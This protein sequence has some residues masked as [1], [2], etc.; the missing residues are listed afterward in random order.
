MPPKNDDTFSFQTGCMMPFSRCSFWK[1]LFYT[2]LFLAMRPL[3][4]TDEIYYVTPN[5]D[6]PCHITSGPCHTLNYYAPNF[7][8][9]SPFPPQAVMYFLPGRHNLNGYHVISF[10][11]FE[12]L[13]LTSSDVVVPSSSVVPFETPSEVICSFEGQAGFVFLFVNNLVIANLT[14]TSCGI[15]VANITAALFLLYD[16]NVTLLHTVIQN[17]T[18]FGMLG[19][20]NASASVAIA[21]SVFLYNGRG[22]DDIGGGIYLLTLP[23]IQDGKKSDLNIYIESSVFMYGDPFG[24]AMEIYY[25]CFPIHININNSKFVGKLPQKRLSLGSN[26][27]LHMIY[28]DQCRRHD[29]VITITNSHFLHGTSQAF[30]GGAFIIITENASYP[31]LCTHAGIQRH[32][33][34]LLLNN[35][36]Q[37]ND[38]INGVGGGLM[39]F[40]V[41]VCQSYHTIGLNNVTFSNNSG[42]AGGNLAVVW[43][44]RSTLHSFSVKISNCTF[45]FGEATTLASSVFLS[46]YSV[47]R[48]EKYTSDR[49]SMFTCIDIADSRFTNNQCILGGALFIDIRYGIHPLC[50]IIVHNSSFMNNS[51]PAVTIVMENPTVHDAQPPAVELSYLDLHYNYVQMTPSPYLNQSANIPLSLTT[52]QPQQFIYKLIPENIEGSFSLALAAMYLK[53]TQNATFINCTFMKN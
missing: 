2:L 40:T 17:S 5:E 43:Y 18:E 6:L 14:F 12:D 32:I 11:E 46:V 52:W 26:L 21:S 27:F 49:T 4:Q 30:G 47:A 22:R 24:V 45:T 9:H 28:S 50:R 34:L 48:M 19:F 44:Q 16:T 39:V 36:F 53:N 1:A 37:G 33:A 8:E 35:V 3:C 23:Y 25:P 41:E 51:S 42:T 13:M 38:A 7:S 15:T 29:S 20:M 10:F 31:N